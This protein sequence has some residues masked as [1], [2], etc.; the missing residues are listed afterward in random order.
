MDYFN[1]LI[2]SINRFEGSYIES[3]LIGNVTSLQKYSENLSN[4]IIKGIDPVL[5]GSDFSAMSGRNKAIFIREEVVP[6]VLSA[7][8]RAATVAY[9]S[10]QEF[11]KKKGLIFFPALADSPSERLKDVVAGGLK[12]IIDEDNI[13]AGVNVYRA[14]F[15]QVVLEAPRSAILNTSEKVTMKTGSPLLGRRVASS[16]ACEFCRGLSGYL[17]PVTNDEWKGWHDFCHCSIVLV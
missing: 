2:E 6:V 12:W 8:S 5:L 11:L 17:F 14:G 1:D 13:E 9:S 10:L 7:N 3:A 15:E 16:G 4:E